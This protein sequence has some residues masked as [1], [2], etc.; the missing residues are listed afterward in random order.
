MGLY[1]NFRA[2]AN[3]LVIFYSVFQPQLNNEI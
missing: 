1:L 3:K 2:A